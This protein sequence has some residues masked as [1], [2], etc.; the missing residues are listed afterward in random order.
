MFSVAP[1]LIRFWETEFE[2]LNPKKN[3]KGIRQY[4]EEDID[5]LKLIYH[6]VKEKGYTIHGAKDILRQERVRARSRMEAI[7]SLKKVRQFLVELKGTL[8]P[9]ARPEQD[10]TINPEQ[11]RDPD[12]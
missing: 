7:E 10:N 3:S 1:S 5:E 6:L 8:K 12:R 9:E 4:T 2:S 11:E